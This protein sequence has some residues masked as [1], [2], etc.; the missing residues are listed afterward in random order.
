M[1][2][3]KLLR[4]R[5]RLIR[6]L[7]SG[8]Y[9][10]L[11]LAQ[12]EE[13]GRQVALKRLRADIFSPRIKARFEQEARLMAALNHPNIAEIY[14]LFEDAGQLYLVMAYCAHGSLKEF[15]GRAGALNIAEVI[16]IGKSVS[17]ALAAAHEKG[18]IHRDVKPANIL[19][20][21]L[22]GGGGV[23]VKLSDFGIAQA[24]Q[25]G[26]GLTRE[27]DLLGTPPYWAP[28][29]VK[30][31]AELRTD[32]YA[33]GAL[34]YGLLAGRHYLDL[35]GA[36]ELEQ[37]R[38]ILRETPAS[39][40]DIRDDVPPWLDEVIMQAL[41]KEPGQRPSA[42]AF[43][44]LL[45]SEGRQAQ[46]D[47]GSPRVESA[48]MTLPSPSSSAW[49]QALVG[50]L[51][52]ALVTVVLTLAY[53][54]WSPVGALPLPA[55]IPENLF[56]AESSDLITGMVKSDVGPV[57]VRA[58]PNMQAQVVTRLADGVSVTLHA[59]SQDGEWLLLRV[60]DVE[61]WM[62]EAYLARDE[63]ASLPVLDNRPGP[64]SPAAVA[65]EPTLPAMVYVG[66]TAPTEGLRLRQNPTLEATVIALLPDGTAV[67][68]HELSQDGQWA[69]VTTDRA[70][71]WVSAQYLY[72]TP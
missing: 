26:D 47:P 71:G 4:G 3:Q 54:N 17:R 51:T 66:S 30:G 9:G 23:E 1:D 24:P 41:Q 48:V 22:P 12:D 29:Q 35:Q 32:V 56:P 33:L 25:G 59:Q 67:T 72:D 62:N 7:G 39:L 28:E 45:E 37:Q 69:R 52:A 11:F 8:G 10:E 2:G 20:S 15:I 65:A 27:G 40:R 13:L 34:L 63:G 18:I 49:T 43:Y 5:Y 58:A 55:N 6:P 46:A 64:E 44:Y 38:R 16:A 50:A 60:D 21:P 57:N 42:A 68:L 14:D 31:R 19:L 36:D 70:E 53:L 61:G